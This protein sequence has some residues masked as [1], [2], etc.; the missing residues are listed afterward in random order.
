MELNHSHQ[1]VFYKN[2]DSVTQNNPETLIVSRCIS[3][4]RS[5]CIIPQ[6]KCNLS[7]AGGLCLWQS[8]I[9]TY[10]NSFCLPSS[11]SW[12]DVCVSPPPSLPLAPEAKYHQVPFSSR[13]H[14]WTADISETWKLRAE[15]PMWITALHSGVKICVYDF[16]AKHFF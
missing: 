1:R 2:H 15:Q 5:L 8:G 16:A 12:V 7:W 6:R 4:L 10:I 13:K 11:Y 9:K 3:S 14:V